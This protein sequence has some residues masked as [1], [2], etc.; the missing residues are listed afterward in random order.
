[1]FSNAFNA[2]QLL[3][4]EFESASEAEIASAQPMAHRCLILAIKSNR[5]LNFEEILALKAVKV[6]QTK[7]KELFEFFSLFIKTDAQDFKG[8]IQKYQKVMAAEQITIE[9]AINKKSYL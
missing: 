6:L 5:V 1:M 3:L 8:Q 2:Y 7:E 9:E 4:Q